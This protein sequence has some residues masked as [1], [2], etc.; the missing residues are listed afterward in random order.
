MTGNKP[1]DVVL[2]EAL[3]PVV[4]AYAYTNVAKSFHAQPHTAQ[5]MNI[6]SVRL[7][8]TCYCSRHI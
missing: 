5:G 8:Y 4:G 2:L 1:N 7:V 6:L 3:F